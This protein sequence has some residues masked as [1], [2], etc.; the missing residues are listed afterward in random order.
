MNAISPSA[1]SALV[2]TT[3]QKF[4]CPICEDSHRIERC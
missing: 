2:V 3:K 1:F 4:R